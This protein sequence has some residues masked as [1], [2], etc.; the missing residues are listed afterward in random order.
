MTTLG[1]LVKSYQG[2]TLT[3]QEI[4]KVNRDLEDFDFLN[5][6]AIEYL[7]EDGYALGDYLW[8]VNDLD[9]FAEDNDIDISNMSKED[10]LNLLNGVI[11]SDWIT[12]EIIEG[13]IRVLD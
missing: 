4:L 11:S 9:R 2:G 3:E 10:K 12:G 5:H 8:H 13:I 1:L 6:V 7:E